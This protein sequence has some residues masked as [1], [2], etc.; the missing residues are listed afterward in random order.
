[1]NLPFYYSLLELKDEVAHVYTLIEH[2][3][4]FY[5][6]LDHDLKRLL[7]IVSDMESELAKT[8]L[9]REPFVNWVNV[10]L[11]KLYQTETLIMS[12]YHCFVI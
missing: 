12:V 3:L 5:Q 7:N 1:M 9:D 11:Q 10:C 6:S 2:D 8:C 4:K